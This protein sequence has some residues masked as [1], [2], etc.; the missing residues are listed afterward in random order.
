TAPRLP[1]PKMDRG[2][3]MNTAL[4]RRYDY[5]T[6]IVDSEV[7]DVRLRFAENQ[8]WP[9]VDL[10]GTYGL[11]GLKNSYGDSFDAATTARTPEWSAGVQIQI[12]WGF[13]KERA[14]L[15]LVKGLK[16]QAILKVKQT[17]LN[18]G[19]DVD[20]VLSRIITNQQRVETARQTRE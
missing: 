12:P 8:L 4:A 9:E 17:E 3:F 20:T 15:N 11:N 19:V 5:L 7:Q 6:A 13:V 16:E 1:V 10:V 2:E 18:V 14:Q